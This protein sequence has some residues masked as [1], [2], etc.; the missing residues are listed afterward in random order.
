[1]AVTTHAPDAVIC[2]ENVNSASFFAQ[3]VKLFHFQIKFIFVISFNSDD[4]INT[5]FVVRSCFEIKVISSATN[6]RVVH[7]FNAGGVH[8]SFDKFGNYINCV[9]GF[10][11][12]CQHIEAVR[13]H[14]QKFQSSFSD[15]T[16]STFTTHYQLFHAVTSAAFFQAS[17]NFYDFTGRSYHFQAI[18]LVTSY[19]ITNCFVTAC[20]SCK[21]TTDLAAFCTAR[22]ACIKEACFVSHF[23]N[24]NGTHASFNNHIHSFGVH[25]DDFVH[26]FSQ[27]NDTTANRDSTVSQTGTA[28]TNGYRHIVFIA[29]FYN[30]SN[31]FCTCRK[32]YSFRHVEF[33]RV[34]FFV[35]FI[36]VKFISS[37]PNIFC[38]KS[39]LQF[40]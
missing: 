14:G 37:S 25:F 10:V 23:L 16:Q 21:V 30:C 17:A 24:V 11:K 18:N 40:C 5:I 31:F 38:T 9:L 34:S 7:I 29:Q 39:S 27:E 20:V 19:T 4:Y 35:S 12:Y 28:T 8:A 36:L 13:S 2:F 3:I 22:I 32:H 15:D 33:F 6:I 26:T 1:M